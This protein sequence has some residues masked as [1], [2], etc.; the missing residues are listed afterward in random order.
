MHSPKSTSLPQTGPC[1]PPN[2]PLFPPRHL[3][4]L[5]SRTGGTSQ[6]RRGRIHFFLL[7]LFFL[8]FVP[9]SGGFNLCDITRGHILLTLLTGGRT[10]VGFEQKE[11]G[12]CL[13]LNRRVL[14]N[15][16]L[17]SPRMVSPALSSPS[18]RRRILLQPPYHAYGVKGIQYWN[19]IREC[20][21]IPQ[22]ENGPLL[23]IPP[24]P[25]LLVDPPLSVIL[26]EQR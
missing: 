1:S 19:W 14:L 12:S 2:R 8:F 7:L 16:L 3:Q 17:V 10:L 4:Q 25:L 20:S 24:C 11:T 9:F 6:H 23:G 26:E 5:E 13:L 22:L 15:C 21:P 18:R